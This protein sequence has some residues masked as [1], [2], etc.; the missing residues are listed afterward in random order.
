VAQR[1]SG[2]R[3]GR[4]LSVRGF[5]LAGVVVLWARRQGAVLAHAQADLSGWG[6]YR[7]AAGRSELARLQVN[8][9][10]A[11]IFDVPALVVRLADGTEETFY[12]RTHLPMIRW[13]LT[14]CAGPGPI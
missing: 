6:D 7:E 4:Y 3:P 10:A 11:D 1:R 2:T 8:L 12:G 14:G 9:G 5:E 13:L